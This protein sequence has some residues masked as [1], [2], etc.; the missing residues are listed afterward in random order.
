MLQFLYFHY[1]VQCSFVIMVICEY[2]V[3]VVLLQMFT[4]RVL[5]YAVVGS[6]PV[7]DVCIKG[8]M[9]LRFESG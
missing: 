5:N 8:V 2:V 1:N 9:S 7:A 4:S 3:M 6:I